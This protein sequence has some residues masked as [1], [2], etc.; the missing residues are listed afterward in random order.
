M[1]TFVGETATRALCQVLV[2][3]CFLMVHIESRPFAQP[4]VQ[5]VQTALL[6][7]LVLIALLNAPLATLQTSAFA[8]APSSPMHGI[9]DQVRTVEAV[10]LVAPG[11]T[12]RS[13]RWWLSACGWNARRWR[14]ALRRL[15][16]TPSRCAQL[17]AVSLCAKP[18]VGRLSRNCSSTHRC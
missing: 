16:A 4:A 2:M 15:C 7:L 8:P 12:S 3:M 5:H 18:A 9:T 11:V 17:R 6:G 14:A 1:Y 13:Q 10:L